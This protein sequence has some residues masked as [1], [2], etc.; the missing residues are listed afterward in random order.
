MSHTT[1]THKL[2]VAGLIEEL[3]FIE[4]VDTALLEGSTATEVAR[5][6]Q[7]DRAAL[8]D[9]NRNTLARELA[10]RK[11]V[12]GDAVD[13]PSTSDSP[14]VKHKLRVKTQRRSLTK[15]MS[16]MNIFSKS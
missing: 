11:Q 14:T 1:S 2:T 13:L 16:G 12:L 4:M 9:V 7:K 15:H 10:R 8:L 3:P 5:F 6:I